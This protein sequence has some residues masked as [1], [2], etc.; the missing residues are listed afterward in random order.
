MSCTPIFSVKET[1]FSETLILDCFGT[2]IININLFEMKYIYVLR[3]ENTSESDPR[4][5]EATNA[6]AKIIK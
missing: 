4:N 2:L 6:V 5:Y 3:I 1:R